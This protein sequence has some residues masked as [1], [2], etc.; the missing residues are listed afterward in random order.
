MFKFLSV[1]FVFLVTL[2]NYTPFIPIAIVVALILLVKR[3]SFSKVEIALY[4]SLMF[5][6]S[7]DMT[8]AFYSS[9]YEVDVRH[10]VALLFSVSVF[11]ILLSVYKK[12]RDVTI[13]NYAVKVALII[14]VSFWIVQVFFL[15]GF[16]Y[17]IDPI[18]YFI[19][20]EQRIWGPKLF[21]VT[22]YRASG[23]A[24]EPSGYAIT[25]APLI[26]LL[27]LFKKRIDKWTIL[28]LLTMI[29]TFSPLAWILVFGFFIFVILQKKS[30][31]LK[32]VLKTTVLLSPILYLV[33]EYL[34]WRFADGKDASLSV[35]QYA[36]SWWMS[37]NEFRQLI[38]SGFGVN[39]CGCLVADSS[40]Y[41]NLFFTYGVFSL[42]FFIL[43]L[44][45][46]RWKIG[47][48]FYIYVLMFAK[49]HFYFLILW[50][51]LAG[52]RINIKC[53]SSNNSG[54]LS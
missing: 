30:F 46:G 16:S 14:H 11:F 52:A 19:G 7:I 15:Y 5:A 43:P 36:V 31:S 47:A 24:N 42:P 23:F 22:I 17:H 10:I 34:L 37:Q 45:L 48:T 49:Y 18:E 50:F 20:Y 28:A 40:L 53:S 8:R 39:D 51:F 27:F 9:F 1:A 54:K 13:F 35:R 33:L 29:L 3:V 25:I 12:E 32:G 6:F 4:L 41:F 21:G 38:G 2:T 44:F 26:Y